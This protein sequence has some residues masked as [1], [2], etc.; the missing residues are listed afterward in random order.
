M[1]LLGRIRLTPLLALLALL[2]GSA[3]DTQARGAAPPAAGPYTLRFAVIHCGGS[4]ATPVYG[5]KVVNTYPHDRE[6][7]TQGLVY[8]D[9]Q[10]YEGTGLF[11]RS[12]L[13]R[14]EVATGKVLQRIDL[15]PIYF[16]EGITTFGDRIIQLTWQNRTGFVYDKASF[17]LEREWSYPT[18]G[19]GITDDGRRLIMS[20]GTATLRFLDPETLRETGKIDVFDTAGPVT[21]LNELEYVDGLIYANVWQ[22][23]R[24][25]QVDPATGRVRA[26]IDLTGLLS[27]ADRAQ[28]VDV[29]NGIAYDDA[30]D[31]L[32][33]TGKL[34]PKV[35]EIDLV[36]PGQ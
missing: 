8:E 19:W 1:R 31:R 30:T 22:T 34:W 29:L 5:Y 10:F 20:D 12:S 36:A 16:G 18:E 9:G 28:P 27:P 4:R 24:I 35:F 26:W 11:G 3:A 25:A 2:A 6:A 17:A 23:D 21:N 7:F 13:R 33:I 32:F 14:V 15:D